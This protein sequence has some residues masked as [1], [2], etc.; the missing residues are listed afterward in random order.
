MLSP[1]SGHIGPWARHVSQWGSASIIVSICSAIV[2]A[3]EAPPASIQ[4]EVGPIQKT[5]EMQGYF[6]P[7]SSTEV[8]VKL[9]TNL[10]LKV[11]RAVEH[12]ATVRTG[13][14]LVE[15]D[16]EDAKEQLQQQEFAL[17][18]QKLSLEE[19]EREARMAEV[20]DPLDAEYAELTK[21]RADEDFAFFLERGFPMNQRSVEQS[22]KSMRDYLDYTAEELRQLEKMYKA[23][24]LT[25]ESEEI[26]LRRARDDL[27]RSRFALE[28]EEL[29]HKRSVE[30]NLPR[31]KRNEE[32]QHRL[33]Q[34]AF[35]QFQL[36]RPL[37]IE[38]RKISLKKQ[39]VELE[40]ASR[41]LDKLRADLKKFRVEAPHDGTVYFGKST[42]GKFGNVAEMFAKL[43]PHGVVSQNEVLMTVV[44]PGSLSFVGSIPESTLDFASSGSTVSIL[45]TAFPKMKIEAK[46][47]RVGGIP[48][49]DG[50]F[51]VQLELQG[52]APKKVVAGMTGKAKWVAY[53]NA[54]AMTIPSSYVRPDPDHEDVS[55]V[56]VLN[57]ESKPERRR[58]EIGI[59]AGD[60][61]EIVSGLSADSKLVESDGSKK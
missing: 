25:E 33:A 15:F 49:A 30:L 56:F 26:V 41:E 47:Q 11:L 23:D 45:P 48:G 16:A 10:N 4:P 61:T 21:H 7:A 18:L 19:A 24:D 13:D 40:K 3:Q 55:Y 37:A 58:V 36:M 57:A 51:P 1:L 6:S 2:L 54:K 20:R 29:N 32:A 53:F 8:S 9:E 31:E 42:D 39:Q 44:R 14:V 12:G 50:N 60:R 28:R 46:L 34:L 43:R 52:D 17:S 38:K 59:V 22:L 35:E 5:V 27:E